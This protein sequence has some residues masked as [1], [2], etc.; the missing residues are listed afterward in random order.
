MVGSTQLLLL[1]FFR[2][3]AALPELVKHNFGCHYSGR[4]SNVKE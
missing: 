2:S 4:G 1:L 3:D